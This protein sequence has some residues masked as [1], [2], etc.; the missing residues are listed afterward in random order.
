MIL[1][2]KRSE[3]LMIELDRII[4]VIL[5]MIPLSIAAVFAVS[6]ILYK[7]A[8]KTAVNG[9]MDRDV[10]RMKNLLAVCRVSG[11]IL[12]VLAL[13]AAILAGL[14]YLFIMNM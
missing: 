2:K 8:K 1:S 4:T 11:I 3:I 14:F 7:K 9:A 10:E 6:L 12:L 13:S 5:C